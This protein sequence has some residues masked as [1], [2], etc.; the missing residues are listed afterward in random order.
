MIA[1]YARQSVEKEGSVSIETQLDYCKS[2]IKIN[3][4]MKDV[5]FYIDKGFSGGN[6]ERP[7][8]Q[9]LIKDIES[10]KIE[11]VIVY[12]LDRISRSLA[13]FMKI[14]QIFEK[15]SVDFVS[16]QEAFDTSSAY[17]DVILKILMVFA[18]F[19][20]TSIIN[21][22]RDAYQ[23]RSDMGFYMGGRQQYGFELNDTLIDD[24]RTKMLVPIER[25]M[26][27]VRFIYTL[28]SSENVSLR[29]VQKALTQNGLLQDTG[30]VWSASKINAILKNPVYVKADID[31]YNYYLSKN[32]R[33]INSPNQF[34]G[35]HA[36]VLYGRTCHCSALGDW[37]DMKLVLAKHEGVIPS[38]I[39][40]KCQQK[41][42]HNKQLGKS[43]SN[44]SSW[45]AGR[46]F[47]GICGSKMTTIKSSR[48]N[49]TKR[50]Y[51][52][53]SNK[54]NKKTC[55]GTVTIYAEDIEDIIQIQ[56]L[57]KLSKINKIPISTDFSKDKEIY[58]V[59]VKLAEIADKESKLKKYI[60]SSKLN[61][62]AAELINSQAEQLY[63][64]Q[65]ILTDR[66][67][68]LQKKEYQQVDTN[69]LLNLWETASCEDKKA[70]VGL[71]I[72]R[73]NISH[74]GDI[75]IIWYI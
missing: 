43:I 72:E 5:N 33:I 46:V 60:L 50:V 61:I 49:G 63:N 28:Y 2:M 37:S 55:P 13:D 58:D 48:S 34:D 29:K 24:K 10:G 45:L 51:F 3:E 11:K 67:T 6:I 59:K 4:Q 17:G 56:I 35:S 26:D 74:N 40:L 38:D 32:V 64:E 23:K 70:T 53:C 57:N 27:H 9:Q 44:S 1:L 7:A 15:H 22:V 65:C 71:I 14:Q 20:R 75:E 69:I 31:I 66:L 42:Q 54:L 41:I 18:E 19:E 52:I 73:I 68:F 36:A 30:Q 21:R 39:W 47:C 16:S 25:Q 12:K 8:F 62:A